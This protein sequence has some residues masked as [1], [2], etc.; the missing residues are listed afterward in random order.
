[1]SAAPA[2][3]VRYDAMCR[4]INDAYVVDEVKDIRD[5][6]LAFEAYAKQARNTEAERRA[7][8][9]RLRAERKAG[10]LLSQMEKAKGARGSGSNQHRV[11][12]RDET[13][14]TLSEIG[15]SKSQSSRWQ[16]LAAVSEEEFE[17]A[18]AAPEKPS[19]SGIIGKPKQEPM[20]PQALWLWGRLRD[21]EREGLLDRNLR[22]ILL[23]M[24]DAMRA[25]ARRLLPSVSDWLKGAVDGR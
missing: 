10:R 8:E 25:D 17:A 23:Q 21:F 2:A 14:P 4:A 6:A 15:V 13:A 24:T 22:D 9:I 18:L 16:R 3:L 5:K 12:S 7:C 20:D 1:M 19:T 11:R